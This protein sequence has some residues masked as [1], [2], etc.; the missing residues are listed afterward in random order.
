MF[1]SSISSDEI[2]DRTFQY[3]SECFGSTEQEII[4]KIALTD[5]AVLRVEFVVMLNELKKW[6]DDNKLNMWKRSAIT[7][8]IDM[9]IS[10]WFSKERYKVYFK[11]SHEIISS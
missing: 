2:M 6:A 3:L 9:N 1:S 10:K 7:G 8:A 4:T 11:L 5:D